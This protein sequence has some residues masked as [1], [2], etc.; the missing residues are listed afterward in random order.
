MQ[1]QIS[2][3]ATNKVK[4]KKSVSGNKA[5]KKPEGTLSEQRFDLK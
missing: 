2:F 3:W 1:N 4:I 5:K